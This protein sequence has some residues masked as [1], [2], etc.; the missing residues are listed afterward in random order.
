MVRIKAPLIA[1]IA[2]LVLLAAA[3]SAAAAEA[4]RWAITATSSPTRL[5]PNS[6]RS[7]VQDLT[8]NATG[9][10]FALAIK[11]GF[12]EGETTA[13]IPFNATASELQSTLEASPSCVGAGNVVVTGGPGATA[14]YVITFVGERA[15]APVSLRPDSSSLTGAS[16]TATVTEATP[17][18]Y[19]EHLI[20][21]TIN[22][23]GAST[24][25]STITLEDALPSALTATAVVGEDSY[26]GFASNGNGIK[27]MSCEAPPAVSCTYSA[28]VDPGDQL[29]MFIT[30]EVAESPPSSLPNLASVSGG[31]TPS[32]STH[33]PLTIGGAPAGFGPTPGSVVVATSTTQ[34]GAHPNVTTAFTMNTKELDRVTANA[35]DVRFDLPPGL[36]SDAARIPQCSMHQILN[37]IGEPHPCPADTMVGMARATLVSSS[38]TTSVDFVTPVYNTAPALG[39]P[40]AFAFEAVLLPVRLDTSVLSDGD[41]AGRVTAPSISE[42]AQTLATAVTIWG[43]PADHDGPGQD[44]SYFNLLHGESFGGPNPNQT[45]IPLLTNPQQCSEPL[46]AEMSADSWLDPGAFVSSGPLSLGT[47]TGCDQLSLSS[48]F[49]LLPG[50]PEAA[51][52]AG[53]KLN[54]HVPQH[55][56]AGALSTPTI[57]KVTTE[58][59]PGTV[60]SPSAATG[61]GVCTDAQ[62][63]G[64]ERGTQRPAQ[65]GACPAASTI[66]TVSAQ[67]PALSEPLTGHVYLAEPNCAPCDSQ[68]AGA[69]QMVRLF[70][71]LTSGEGEQA[72][73][74]KLQGR[75][76]ID[77]QTGQLTTVFD[78]N[79]PLPFSELELSL[80]S[81]PRA[82]LANPRACGA[83][84]SS[85]DLEPWGAPQTPDSLTSAGFEVS[86]GCFAPRFSPSFSAGT[87]AL[88][89][90]A[91]SPFEL[92]FGRTDQDQFLRSISVSTPPGLLAKIA[93]IP[94]C[95][96]PQAGQGTCDQASLIGH[97]QALAGPGPDPF[98]INGGQ[99]FLTDGYK[100]APYGLSIV[101][102]AKAGPFTL[103]GTNG[104][105][106]VVVR[107]A[108]AVDP[109]DAH[110][111]ITSDPLPTMLDGIPL[112]IRRVD[113]KV[114]RPGF[115]FNPTS[116]EP[117]SVA[118]EIASAEGSNAQVSSRFQVGEC[119]ALGFKPKL[120][121]SLTGQM[122][123]TG[124]PALKAVLTYPKGSHANIAR[125][126]VTLPGS[127]LL[128]N[129]RI[130]SP[131]TRVQFAQAA[132]PPGS[133][134]GY[135]RAYTPLLD[136]P[137]EG[138][139]YLMTGFGHK[140][141]DVV[142]DLNGQLHV[143]LDGKV[144]SGREGGLRNTF[145]AV[146]D[147]PVSKFVLSLKGGR[148]G[149]LQNSENLC[150]SGARRTAV[151]D[152]TAQNG[153]ISDSE[154]FVANS[155]AKHKHKRKAHR[156]NR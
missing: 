15:N 133:V 148:V 132:C 108:I 143:L 117:M 128:D 147:A 12:C 129:A 82:A 40:A 60:L 102:P 43:V 99:V 107:S 11:Q 23:G 96:E 71:Q 68:Q 135:A 5:Q 22:V 95:H 65:P 56:E 81:G 52:P 24:D 29:I 49:S 93:G 121:L 3:S 47:L 7:E 149:L 35:K 119:A 114:D 137:L 17:G 83:V 101:V 67:T 131:C 130:N 63:F 64:G 41:Y 124:H 73:V 109:N 115:T 118:A 19:P 103:A 144:D 6:P 42:A 69:G 97:V 70:I 151:A 100:G 37:Q 152:F 92:T 140:L 105:G 146:P 16:A 125:A 88:Q 55:N 141:P 44:L 62:F 8:V 50:T 139:V 98:Q 9:G 154:P 120:A 153:R 110:L 48:T 61:L 89:A 51:A 116:C 54:L 38:P 30:L 18:A 80:T 13:P 34:A 1:A 127:E 85:M 36:V 25:A 28:P 111:T 53:Y 20:V 27:N 58:L 59:P 76:E 57:R 2:L 156:H 14:P 77:Q 72:V 134:L 122:H 33:N 78:E 84:S 94:L 145:L 150:S 4:P 10:T 87:A 79:P 104:N 136:N 75:G 26:G 155:C 86:Q 46:S 126:Q 39:E 106:A 31:G 91:Y 21:T 112:Q 66:G 32:A 138:P 90:G 45:R 74:I 142:A 113:V 123:R